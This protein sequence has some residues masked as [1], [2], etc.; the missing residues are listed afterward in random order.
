MYEKRE[1]VDPAEIIK[2]AWHSFVSLWLWFNLI[3][4][5]FLILWP[6]LQ[7]NKNFWYAL[8]FNELVWLLDIIRKFFDKPKKSRAADSYEVAVEYIKSTL[9]LDVLSSLP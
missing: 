6:E 1:T 2:P 8:W 7:D 5:P 9:I 4:S 3:T